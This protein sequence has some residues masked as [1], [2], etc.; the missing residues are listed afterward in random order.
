MLKKGGKNPGT[1]PWSVSTPKVNGLFPDPYRILPP[2]FVLIC[3]VISVLSSF[4]TNQPTNKYMYRGE[5]IASFAQSINTYK[6]W[7]QHWILNSTLY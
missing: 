3:P 5:N 1:A 7:H 4:H 6:K 2:G